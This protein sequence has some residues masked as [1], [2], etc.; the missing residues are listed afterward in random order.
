MQNTGVAVS[1]ER[2]GSA[3][4]DG[5][6]ARLMAWQHLAQL[7]VVSGNREH[8]KSLHLKSRGGLTYCG[9]PSLGP[10]EVDASRSSAD[11]CTNCAKVWAQEHRQRHRVDGE[12]AI[13]A[14][15]S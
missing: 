1:G 3:K 12:C 11:L 13:C 14:G 8:T 5:G 10:L 7:Q 4:V 6:S 9:R 2:W 15:R